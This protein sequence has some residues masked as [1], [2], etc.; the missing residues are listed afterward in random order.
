MG[1]H[2]HTSWTTD[3]QCIQVHTCDAHDAGHQGKAAGKAG[4]RAPRPFQLLLVSL[5]SKNVE[6]DKVSYVMQIRQEAGCLYGAFP[7]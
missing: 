7:K 5:Q 1:P 6:V 3:K 4:H 2:L